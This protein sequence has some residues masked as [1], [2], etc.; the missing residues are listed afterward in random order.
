VITIPLYFASSV[1]LPSA[2]LPG[3][4]TRLRLIARFPDV[5][6]PWPFFPLWFPCSLLE[7]SL[8]VPLPFRFCVMPMVDFSSITTFPVH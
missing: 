4:D 1:S 2:V 5:S 7:N 6:L 8:L 3:G